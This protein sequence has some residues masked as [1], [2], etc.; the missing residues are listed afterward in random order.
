MPISHNDVLAAF[1]QIMLLLDNTRCIVTG[2]GDTATVFGFPPDEVRGMPW[3]DL[4]QTAL[5]TA[6]DGLYW[7]VEAALEGYVKSEFLPAQ[8][9]F[10]PD[11]TL[12]L[13]QPSPAFVA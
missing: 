1:S 10:L 12:E 9:P 13:R 5:P 11:L 8:L 7:A 4:I 3:T 6:M 2:A